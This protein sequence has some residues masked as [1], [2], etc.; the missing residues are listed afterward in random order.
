MCFVISL[1]NYFVTLFPNYSLCS[2]KWQNGY[3]RGLE[4][5]GKAMNLHSQGS[6]FMTQYLMLKVKEVL[7]ALATDVTH[8]SVSKG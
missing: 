8:W 7:R 6:R 5:L 2:S 4:G 1:F 3:V